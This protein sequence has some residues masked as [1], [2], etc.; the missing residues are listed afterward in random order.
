MSA[1]NIIGCVADDDE[2]RWLKVNVL[3]RVH[4]ELGPVRSRALDLAK[5]T[6]GDLANPLEDHLARN[7]FAAKDTA[8]YCRVSHPRQRHF[9]D[10]SG[11]AEDRL[12]IT[13]LIL[14]S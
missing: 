2:L 3:V 1:S 9:A 8:I 11:F 14:C 6:S 5:V 7:T 4:T 13:P 10:P 12:Q